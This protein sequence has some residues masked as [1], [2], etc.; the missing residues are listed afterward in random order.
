M[1]FT[2][3]M[4]AFLVTWMIGI[5]FGP[6]G[7][8][9]QGREALIEGDRVRVLEIAEQLLKTAGLEPQGN[10]LKGLILARAGMRDEA[11]VCL[12]R[13]AINPK[14]AVEANTI[15]ARCCYESGRYLHAIDAA[16]HALQQDPHA[17]DARRW[18]ASA[19]YDLGAVSEATTEMEHIS[20]HDPTDARPDRLLGLIAKDSELYLKAISHYRKS[21]ERDP[22]QSGVEQVLIELAESQTKVDQFEEALTTL[23]NA[24]RSAA[25]LTIQAQCNTSLGRFELAESQLIEA[26]AIDPQYSPAKLAMGKRMLDEGRAENAAQILVVARQLEPFNREIQ[27]QL[28]QAF[29]AMGRTEEAD[30]ALKRMLEIQ[31]WERE[32]SD[33]HDQ[34]ASHPDDAEIRYRTGELANRLGK[35]QLAV[36][37]FRAALSIDPSHSRSREALQQFSQTTK[38]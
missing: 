4:L 3:I 10:L 7:L 15:T 34:V 14:L 6:E 22:R 37:W 26:M 27:L 19:Y 29:R 33:L 35:S 2:L 25:T 28:S 5:S 9:R 16:L 36:L 38:P 12:Q 21:L 17:L 18:L 13:A 20:A 8:Y 11:I 31:A 24:S 1:F 32:F 23:K 30:V